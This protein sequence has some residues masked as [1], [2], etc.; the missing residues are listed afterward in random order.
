MELYEDMFEE[1]Y[2]SNC[3]EYYRGLTTQYLNE[4]DVSIYV[5]KVLRSVF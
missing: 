2:L 3:V 5:N 1:P 4:F